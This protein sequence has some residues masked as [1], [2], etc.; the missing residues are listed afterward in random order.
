VKNFKNLKFIFLFLIPFILGSIYIVHFESELFKSSST[1]LIKDLKSPQV[2]T[3][4]LGSL[5]Q[6]A[7]SNMQD[8]KLMEKYIYSWEMFG[9]IDREFNLTKHYMSRDL[10]FLQRKYSFSRPDS[11]YNLYQD[12]LEVNYDELSTTLDIAFLHTNPK[13]AK[14]ILE[15]I[16]KEAEKRLNRFNKENG[17]ELL[18]FLREQVKKNK[19]IL[20]KSIEKLLEYQNKHKM[21]DPSIDIKSKSRIIAGLEKQII[22]KEIEYSN[23]IKYM[24]RNTVEVKSLKSQIKN[25][26]RKLNSV[27]SKLSGSN[28]KELNRNLFEFERLKSDVEFN[29]ERYKQTLIQLDLA[30][31][32]ATQNAKNFITVIKPTLP[33]SYYKPDKIKNIFTLF[34]VLFLFYGIASMIYAIIKDHKD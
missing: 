29:K 24:N 31:I 9:M 6:N 20:F 4:M 11:F 8:S 19:E 3:N 26:K 16:I 21:I 14:E 34:I 12:R 32:E 33:K 1:I 15:F 22:Q 30:L 17:K 25:L 2:N 13:R 7:S 18:K 23:L 27:K 28:K 5:F 10:D